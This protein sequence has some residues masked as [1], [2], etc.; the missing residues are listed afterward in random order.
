MTLEFILYLVSVICL[1][2]A[3]L[4]AYVPPNPE[5]LVARTPW[6]PLGVFFFVLVFCIHAAP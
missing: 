1:G 5:G 4:V 2:V 3:V 6:F